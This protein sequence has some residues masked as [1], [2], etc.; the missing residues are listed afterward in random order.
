MTRKIS[1][2]GATFSMHQKQNGV[3]IPQ[4]ATSVPS[5]DFAY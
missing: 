2:F 5:K 1:V 3:D 4:N